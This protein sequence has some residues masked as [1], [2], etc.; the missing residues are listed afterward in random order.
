MKPQAEG[1]GPFASKWRRFYARAVFLPTLGWNMFLGRILK[2]R[3]WWDY[4]DPHVMVGAYPFAR[5]VEGLYAEGVRAVVNTCEEYAGPIFEYQRLAI[6]QLCIPTTDFT[7][8]RLEDVSRAVDFVETHV[9]QGNKV[10][11]HCKAGRARSA[12]VALC[13][14]IKYRNLT[15]EELRCTCNVQGLMSI[16][17]SVS[18]RWF[19]R[20]LQLYNSRLKRKQQNKL[21][22]PL[23]HE[24]QGTR[25]NRSAGAVGTLP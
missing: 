16:R 13:W 1:L 24:P 21:R 10:Y 23:L 5:D 18:G 12:T 3:R 7:H 22:R 2:V 4:I 11:I 25:A 9:E 17:L 15:A 6:D 14:L 20:L 19:K 8:P